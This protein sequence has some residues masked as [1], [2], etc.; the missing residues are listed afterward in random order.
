MSLPSIHLPIQSQPH[1][2]NQ[3]SHQTIPLTPLTT[4]VIASVNQIRNQAIY[5]DPTYLTY[6]AYPV[7]SD[8]HTIVMRKGFTGKQI[9]AVFSNLGASGSG[10]WP[11]IS[12]LVFFHTQLC[13]FLVYIP[14]FISSSSIF[15]SRFT[16][17]ANFISLFMYHFSPE[18]RTSN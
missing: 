16:F 6:K 18:D 3:S 17:Q 10:M 8:S 4:I 5:V 15:L 13:Y 11:F 14:H 9:I 7:Y 12:I 2:Q 1:L